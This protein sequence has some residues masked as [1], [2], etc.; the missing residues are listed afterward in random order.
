MWDEKVLSSFLRSPKYLIQF[1]KRIQDLGILKDRYTFVWQNPI[2]LGDVSG[3]CP[4]RYWHLLDFSLYPRSLF[5]SNHPDS[6][7]LV[8]SRQCHV[9]TGDHSFYLNDKNCRKV[10]RTFPNSSLRQSLRDLFPRLIPIREQRLRY[11]HAPIP[12]KPIGCR[13]RRP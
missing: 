12:I 10:L 6:R 4:R 8:S 3:T 13:D 2:L 11:T 1:V 9:A 5:L 7:T